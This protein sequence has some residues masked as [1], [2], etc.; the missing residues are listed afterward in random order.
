MDVNKNIIRQA[1]RPNGDNMHSCFHD[2][3]QGLSSFSLIARTSTADACSTSSQLAHRS[4]LST[5]WHGY[6]DNKPCVNLLHSSSTRC[7]SKGRQFASTEKHNMENV[8][9]C[10][11]L[12]Q[13]TRAQ[14]QDCCNL[15]DHACQCPKMYCIGRQCWDLE[16]CACCCALASLQHRELRVR[17]PATKRPTLDPRSARTHCLQK[18]VS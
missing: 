1:S 16:P 14:V 17:T 8:R 12:A 13:A 18:L 2:N 6:C 7:Q 9:P 4:C 5:G 15:K 10:A 3:W 11:S